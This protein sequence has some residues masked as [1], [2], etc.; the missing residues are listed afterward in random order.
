MG[1]QETIEKLKNEL[2]EL[3]EKL[4]LLEATG[5]K[6]GADVKSTY[7]EQVAALSARRDKLAKILGEAERAGKDLWE[8]MARDF[9]I[10]RA[11]LEAGI[12]ELRAQYRD[13]K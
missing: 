1:R 6:I 7:T 8:M 3:N 4:D 9:E 2:D 13:Q 5:E 12:T 10:V 11:G